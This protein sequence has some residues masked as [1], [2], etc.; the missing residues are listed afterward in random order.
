LIDIPVEIDEETATRPMVRVPELDAAA[1][2]GDFT[3]VE[4][5]YSMAQ[6]VNEACRCLRCDVGRRPEDA[7]QD[8]DMQPAGV[9]HG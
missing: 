6:A 4:L 7:L 2:R 8:T 1:R 5:S 3:E 9:Q